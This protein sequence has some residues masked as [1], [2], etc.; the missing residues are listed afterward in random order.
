MNACITLRDISIVQP[1]SKDSGS[2]RLRVSLVDLEAL[3]ANVGD[4]LKVLLCEEG[5][6]ESHA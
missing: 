3:K 6:S 4:I 5:K 1:T 2:G